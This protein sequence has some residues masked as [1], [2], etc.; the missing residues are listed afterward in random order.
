[1]VQL[2][3]SIQ[4]ALPAS[5]FSRVSPLASFRSDVRR[6]FD[7][8][9]HP[10]QAPNSLRSPRPAFCRL[11]LRTAFSG[12]ASETVA[13]SIFLKHDGRGCRLVDMQSKH[14]RSG[15]VTRDVK[16]I[17]PPGKFVE[18]EVGHEQCTLLKDRAGN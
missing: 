14:V 9:R 5:L 18:V 17:L 6:R 11:T 10:R 7:C 1:M 12:R 4:S 8:E 16:V 15:V 2:I 13:E 3:H